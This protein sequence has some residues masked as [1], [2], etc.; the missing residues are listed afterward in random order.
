MANSLGESD[1]DRQFLA[2]PTFIIEHSF[3]MVITAHRIRT[4]CRVAGVLPAPDQMPNIGHIWAGFHYHMMHSLENVNRQ[5]SSPGAAI[6]VF[7]RIMDILHVE[8][9]LLHA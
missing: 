9:R 4:A 8:V 5:I 1:Y 3:L 6:G 7:Y 2:P